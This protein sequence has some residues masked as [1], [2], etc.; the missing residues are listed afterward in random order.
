MDPIVISDIESELE[1]VVE[2]RTP[3]NSFVKNKI[4]EDTIFEIEDKDITFEEHLDMEQ[5]QVLKEY[6]CEKCKAI[7]TYEGSCTL[8]RYATLEEYKQY[9]E[10]EKRQKE[11]ALKTFLNKDFEDLALFSDISD[12]SSSDFSNR[13][14]ED[15]S[16]IEDS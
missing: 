12:D 14:Y 16:V 3:N 2:R 11:E 8:V 5:R 7:Y 13:V 10:K 9:Q 6:L 4:N 15:N 1:T